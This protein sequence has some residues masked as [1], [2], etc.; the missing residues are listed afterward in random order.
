[1]LQTGLP[2]VRK[3]SRS[4]GC[5]LLQYPLLCPG[6]RTG[7][8]ALP[9][10]AGKFLSASIAQFFMNRR[11][12]LNTTRRFFIGHSGERVRNGKNGKEDN[13]PFPTCTKLER[14]FQ[15]SDLNFTC[16]IFPWQPGTERR[17]VTESNA[18]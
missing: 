8:Y 12:V 1:L 9:I 15:L 7:M 14:D 5:A 17:A 4:F 3:P 11:V 18:G 16:G 6:V 2:S 13:S 10:I